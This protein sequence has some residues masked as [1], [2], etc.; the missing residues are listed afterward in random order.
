MQVSSHALDQ[1]R[2]EGLEFSIAGFTHLGLI[3][4]QIVS[5]SNYTLSDSIQ[6]II[7]KDL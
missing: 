3:K 7:N 5:P 1:K 2:V 4:E 6:N